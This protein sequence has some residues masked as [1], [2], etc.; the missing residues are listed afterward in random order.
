L[1]SVDGVHPS[2]LGYWLVAKEFIQAINSG[3]GA[4]IP[5]PKLPLGQIRTLT[6]ATYATNGLLA[7][8]SISAEE[9]ADFLSVMRQ[10]R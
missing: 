6:D 7:A 4:A 9:W 8:Y 1:F 2:S 3:Y 5:A 10:A